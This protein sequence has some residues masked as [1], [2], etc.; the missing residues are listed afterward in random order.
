MTET[1]SQVLLHRVQVLHGGTGRPY[2]HVHATLVDPAWSYW[3]LRHR[4]S[5]LLL[6]TDARFAPEEPA[7]TT[8]EIEVTELDMLERFQNGGVAQIVLN[9]GTDEERTLTLPVQD[10]VLEVTLVHPNG[11]PHTGR[12][13]EARSGAVTVPLPALN[14]GSNVYRSAPTSWDP[15]LQPFGIFA[16]G[17]RQ[18]YASLDYS[19]PV[20]RLRAVDP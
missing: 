13:V 11:T 2:G 19:R 6:S 16:N 4:G 17:T 15:A 10:V 8:L 5:D 1:I 20:T 9:Q 14:A 12:T 18:T 7:T 3:R